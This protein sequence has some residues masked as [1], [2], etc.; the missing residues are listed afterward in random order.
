MAGFPLK[1][2]VNEAYGRRGSR[3]G[4]FRGLGAASN[5]HCPHFGASL[6]PSRT[7]TA[8][9]PTLT[10]SVSAGDALV[11]GA[12]VLADQSGTNHCRP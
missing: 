1:R 12:E 2:Y 7:Q 10:A 5:V 9:L 8:A 3:R 6:V 11:K 4:I